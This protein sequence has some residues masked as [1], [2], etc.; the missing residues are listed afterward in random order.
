MPDYSILNSLCEEFDINVLELL[1]GEK[2]KADNK[3][4]EEYMKYKN[5]VLIRKRIVYFIVLL[6]VIV[7]SLLGI[8]FVSNY[9]NVTVYELTGE[10]EHF[11]YDSGV[12][13]KSNIK[14]VMQYGKLSIKSDSGIEEKAIVNRTLAYKKDND[15]IALTPFRNDIVVK[16]N[17]GYSEIF[18]LSNIKYIPNE[19]YIVVFY[20]SGEEIKH[21]ELKI[22]AEEI[23]KN[24]KLVNLREKFIG[25]KK[26]EE[27]IDFNHY[28]KRNEYKQFLLENGF[29]ENIK[30]TQTSWSASVVEKLFGDHEFF[31]INYKN[32]NIYYSLSSDDFWLKSIY[33]HDSRIP[34]IR[35]TI[36]SIKDKEMC[37]VH[38]NTAENKIDDRENCL[39]KYPFIEE[40]INKYMDNYKKYRLES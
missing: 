24:D 3:V 35:F 7:G 6:L 32:G 19:L 21:E 36:S 5:K 39:K 30:W 8:Y 18:D 29:S 26:N 13:L 34:L 10:S 23:M 20:K 4:F 2:K 1:N 14:Y 38:Y 37:S 11:N 40:H 22:N 31:Q 25:D 9:K 27:K 15:Y 28:D 16:E 12:F 33:Y 17:Y